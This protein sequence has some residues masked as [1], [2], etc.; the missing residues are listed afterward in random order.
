MDTLRNA[1][2]TA[3]TAMALV[4]AGCGGDSSVSSKELE[5]D[6]TAEALF[7][8]SLANSS[9]PA[10]RATAGDFLP[11]PTNLFLTGSDG[12]VNIPGQP[13]SKTPVPITDPQNPPASYN[14]AE[15]ALNTMDGFATTAPMVVRFSAPVTRR[16]LQNGGIRIFKAS[17]T[18][19][20]ARNYTVTEI[21]R[22]LVFGVDFIASPLQS[23]ALILPL[24]PLDPSSTYLVVVTDAAKTASGNTVKADRDYRYGGM[25]SPI[26]ELDQPGGGACDF[27]SPP[28]SIET[29]CTDIKRPELEPDDPSKL[30]AQLE[31]VVYPLEGLRQGS[32]GQQIRTHESVID[33]DSTAP[34]QY[35]QL[36]ELTSSDIVLSYH[37]TTQDVG[38]ALEEAYSEVDDAT[39]P[40]LSVLNGFSAW[41]SVGG[42]GPS[43]YEVVTP[44]DDGEINDAGDHSGHVYLGTLGG[45]LQFLDPDNQNSSKWEAN[46]ADS[47]VGT[48]NLVQANSYDPELEEADDVPV[49]ITAPKPSLVRSGGACEAQNANGL[50]VVIYQHGITSNRATMLAIA[51]S[52]A[53]A[54]VVS[55]GI[56]LPKHGIY[57]EFFEGLS[58]SDSAS[59]LAQLNSQFGGAPERLV[60]GGSST[61]LCTQQGTAI[62]IPESSGTYYCPSSDFINLPNLAN[63]RDA[64]RQAVVDLHSLYTAIESDVGSLDIG[65]NADGN[66]IHF[67]GSSLGGIVGATFAGLEPGLQTVTLNA[68]SGGVAKTLDG[69]PTFSPQIA[70]GLSNFGINKPSGDYEGFLIIAQTLFDNTD[71]INFTQDV[72]GTG[73]PVLMQQVVGE[74]KKYNTIYACNPESVTNG[75]PDMVVPNNVFGQSPITE[76]WRRVSESEQI[77]H[78]S[79]QFPL[80]TPVA[81]AGTDPLAQGTGFFTLDSLGQGANGPVQPGVISGVFSPYPA[82]GFYGLGLSEV[83]PGGNTPQPAAQTSGVVRFTRGGH[84]SLLDPSLSRRVT[85]VMQKQLATYVASGGT[86]IANETINLGQG[87]IEAEVVRD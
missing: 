27:S 1:L 64:F 9:D 12:S 18:A 62:E 54:C 28:G 75:C 43:A 82:S 2:I 23:N 15:T 25:T 32:V 69:S 87:R 78:L 42:G 51:D 13:N 68:A 10:E 35:P 70:E 38:S 31:E 33:S 11:F 81:L 58:V 34:K 76:A 63:S 21:E 36:P 74:P 67:V 37:V 16:S 5:Q 52:L 53:K 50:P 84:T 20:V 86:S 85:A 29:N 65:V 48:T 30:A 55:I 41:P 8:P 79:G 57:P 17:S 71:P 22:E 59:Q 45:A 14:P 47:M 73:T 3:S 77:S 40:T 26:V 66:K 49:L 46:P 56:D 7:Q 83:G 24:Q 6:V 19:G 4:L 80:T 44:G 72:S 39:A 61:G 60:T